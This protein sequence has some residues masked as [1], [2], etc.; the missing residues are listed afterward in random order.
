[1]IWGTPMHIE[2]GTGLFG[3]FDFA[4]ILAGIFVSTFSGFPSLCWQWIFL[5]HQCVFLIL[6][7]N[8]PAFQIMF[9]FTVSKSFF[10]YKYSAGFGFYYNLVCIFGFLYIFYWIFYI[11]CYPFPRVPP[12]PY[13]S[14]KLT[15][16][17]QWILKPVPKMKPE[18]L[19]PTKE[20]EG[21]TWN[22]QDTISAT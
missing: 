21:N 9:Q 10:N 20:W 2:R 6:W 4:N 7:Y 18:G 5:N 1:M 13:K 3:L 15:C 17:Y 22:F 12:P 16:I 19:L 8:T 11:S 14:A